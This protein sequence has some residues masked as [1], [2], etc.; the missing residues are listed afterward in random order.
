MEKN[1][2]IKEEVL[3]VLTPIFGDNVR[4]II[5]EYYDSNKP[6]EIIELAH[7]M[8]S[9]YMGKKNADRILKKIIQ[10]YPKIKFRVH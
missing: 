4:K 1:I 9:G 6:E 7:H 10:N 8:L 2:K 3:K 5:N